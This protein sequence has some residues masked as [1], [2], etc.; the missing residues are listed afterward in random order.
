MTP[1]HKEVKD[2]Y[3]IYEGVKNGS[4][5][6]TIFK[7]AREKL[8]KKDSF[9][10]QIKLPKNNPF[11]KNYFRIFSQPFMEIFEVKLLNKKTK[12]VPLLEPEN[13]LDLICEN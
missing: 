6:P 11:K 1:S 7:E 3:K 8:K 13:A 12:S 2:F 9:S 10:V 5:P 4:L